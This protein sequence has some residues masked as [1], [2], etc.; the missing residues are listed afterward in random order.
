MNVDELFCAVDNFCQ[1]FIPAWQRRQLSSG[2]R[3]R[4]RD[5]RLTASELMTIIIHFHHQ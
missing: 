5:R 2:E 1:V 4:Q 3:K